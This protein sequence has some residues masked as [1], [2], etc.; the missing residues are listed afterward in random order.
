MK[1]LGLILFVSG[2]L[3][4]G[5]LSAAPLQDLSGHY[6]CVIDDKHDGVFVVTDVLTRDKPHS[7]DKVTG[8]RVTIL[9][10]R[11]RPSPYFGYASFD[12]QSLAMYSDRRAAGSRDYA[13]IIAQL[14]SSGF[15]THYYQPTYKGGNTGSAACLKIEE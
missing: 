9:D 2:M 14:T 8:Y 11:G 13:I 1:T 15:D 3:L 10:E 12:G 5:V 6:K 4:S 7:T